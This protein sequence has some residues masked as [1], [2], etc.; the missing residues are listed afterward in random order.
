MKVF[1]LPEGE[2]IIAMVKYSPPGLME[3]VF[4]AT[5]F[6]VYELSNNTLIP[7]RF[8]IPNES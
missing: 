4:V 7:L 5:S 2:E 6:G 1:R 8:E 3:R